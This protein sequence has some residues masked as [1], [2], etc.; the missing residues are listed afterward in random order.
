MITT[1]FPVSA[2]LEFLKGVHQPGDVY[3]IALYTGKAKLGPATTEYSTSNE[4]EGKGYT[5]GGMI[6]SGYAVR[7]EKGMAILSF[8][9]AK[10]EQSSISARGLLIYNSTRNNRVIAV[11]DF[12]EVVTSTNADFVAKMPD[13]GLITLL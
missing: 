9:N 4:V 8:G 12:G 10:W 13:E 6:L 7:E 5:A 3:K 2:K 1:A 11:F